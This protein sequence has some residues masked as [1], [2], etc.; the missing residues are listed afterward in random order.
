MKNILIIL[1]LTTSLGVIAQRQSSNKL[2]KNESE[3]VVAGAPETDGCAAACVTI[4]F[5]EAAYFIIDLMADHHEYLL[6]NLDT[7]PE[8]VSFEGMFLAAGGTDNRLSV[9][10]RIRGTAGVFS[11][12]FRFNQGSSFGS[13]STDQF[14]EWQILEFNTYPAEKVNLRFGTGILF[15]L[16]DN[17]SYNEHHA[18]L[19]TKF[20]EDKMSFLFEGRY[21]AD[22]ANLL[23][24][25]S[26][27]TLSA[28][29]KAINYS[30]LNGYLVL[31][32][33]YQNYYN[34]KDIS[35]IQVGLQFSIH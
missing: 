15:N 13:S 21:A 17:S 5:S 10:P 20:F 2:F 12:D 33:I 32:G 11:T 6:D 9:L 25:Y 3:N 35:G 24:I 16:M 22:Y 7:Y 19:E 26:E 18:S 1:F 31:G 34:T 27:I 23:D 28:K 29:I 14:F 30:H 8:A 4:L